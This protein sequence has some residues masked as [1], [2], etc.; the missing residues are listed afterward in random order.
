M[1]AEIIRM[2]IE[3]IVGGTF[4]VTIATLRASRKKAI[5]EAR[6]TAIDNDKEL[7]INF[8]KFIVEPLKNEVYALR[9]D[10]QMFTR[11]VAKINS[12]HAAATCP[13]HCELQNAKDNNTR[14]D[15]ATNK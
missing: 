3:V 9:K 4:L 5:E 1:T 14:A 13:V 2:V 15:E 8:H 6:R 10:V 7:I 12:C 11:A